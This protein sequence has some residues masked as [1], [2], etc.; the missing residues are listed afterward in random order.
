MKI[1]VTGANGYVGS[2][3]IKVLLDNHHEI[4]AVD[5][6]HNN[7]DERAEKI[8]ADVFDETKGFYIQ[9]GSPETVIHLA[10]QDVPVHNSMSHINNLPKHFNFLKNLIDSGISQVISVGSMH[11]I[12]YYEGRIDENTVPNPQTIYGLSK[13][14]LRRLLEIYTKDKNTVFQWLRFYYTFGDDDKSSGSIF[15][16]ILQMEKEGK[17]KF[18]FTNGKNQYDYIHINDLANQVCAVAEQKE[19]TGIINC[20]SGKPTVI[21]DKVEDFLKE[22]NLKIRPDFGKFPSRPYDSPCVYGNNSKIL[23]IINNKKNP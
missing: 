5:F 16:K 10:W 9:W 15:S 20:C 8:T 1:A 18:P 22:N 12:G 11:D 19:V 14:T 4:L 7:V 2:H 6:L 17:T 23:K 13:D 3:L 21:K